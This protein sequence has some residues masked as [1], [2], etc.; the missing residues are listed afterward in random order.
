MVQRNAALARRTD[1]ERRWKHVRAWGS[2]LALFG[3]LVLLYGS[4]TPVIERTP[5]TVAITVRDYQ[6]GRQQPGEGSI[7]YKRTFQRPS[8]A[9]HVRAILYDTQV[10]PGPNPG[11]NCP[12][13][14][15]MPARAWFFT[16]SWHNVPVEWVTIDASCLPEHVTTLRGPSLEHRGMPLPEGWNDMHDLTALPTP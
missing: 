8:L 16:F 1:S 11:V 13:E 9:Q 14:A 5:D 4:A 7:V 10:F 15:P 2:V 12:M 6:K 3:V